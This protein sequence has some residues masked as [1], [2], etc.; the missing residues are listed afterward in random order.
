MATNLERR[1]EALESQRSNNRPAA[2][3]TDRE[4]LAIIAPD[5]TGPMPSSSELPAMIHAWMMKL[6]PVEPPPADGLSAQE[7]YMRMLGDP[8]NGGDHGRA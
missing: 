5:H 4:M 3:K 7:R 2:E 6:G 1:I 8:M